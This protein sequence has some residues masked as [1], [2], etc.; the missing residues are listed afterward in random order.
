MSNQMQ[1]FLAANAQNRQLLLATSLKQRKRLTT[2]R[3]EAG[4]TTRTKLY[5]VGVLTSVLLNISAALTI[6][7]AVA[8]PSAKAPYNLI[9]RLRITDYNGTDRVNVSGFM[10]YVWNSVRARSLYG[11]NN[12]AAANDIASQ[13]NVPTAVGNANLTFLMEVPIAYDIDNKI[14]QLQDTRGAMLMQTGVGEVYMHIDWVDNLITQDDDDALYKGGATSTVA[15][16]G[17][18]YITCAVYQNF[19][20]P[21]AV[22]G[23]GRLPL[24]EM[25][26]RT[27]YELAGNVISSD[28]ISAGSEKL[29]PYPNVRAVLGAYFIYMDNDV[30]A[31]TLSNFT[32]RVNGSTDLTEDDLAT[33]LH[34]QRKCIGSDVQTG[35]FFNDHRMKPIETQIYGNVEMAIEP[36]AVTS[37][38][39]FEFGFETFYQYGAAL[40]GFSQNQ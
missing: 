34:E 28:N 21:Q 8:T 26:L 5:N 7:T 3:T 24:P 40:P 15:G 6:G 14:Q 20:L 37:N 10:L 4:Q 23:T 25:D 27:V 31:N 32:L 35:V 38:P 12:S 2:I 39:N 1:Q 11:Q 17:N 22:Q 9:K 33:K 16:N 36:S 29:I 18:D 19:L 13:P 30:L